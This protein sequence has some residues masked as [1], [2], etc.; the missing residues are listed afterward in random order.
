MDYIRQNRIMG[1]SVTVLVVLNALAL[2]TLWWTRLM[3]SDMRIERPMRQ[4]TGEGRGTRRGPGGPD[5]VEFIE[6]ELTLDADQTQAFRALRRQFFQDSFETLRTIHSLK[7]SLLQ[8]VF[9]SDTDS[10]Q[11][12]KLAGDIG[13]LQAS[14]EIAQANHFEQIKALCTPEQKEHF[15]QLIDDVLD[16]TRPQGPGGG[17]GRGGPGMRGGMRRGS[18]MNGP[19]DRPTAPPMG[20]L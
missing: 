7:Q 5:V 9:A 18:P 11:I 20:G 16:M 14:L 19:P 17:G 2:G 12:E 4:G 13:Q 10:N 15:M 6:R 8:T 1:W 3:P